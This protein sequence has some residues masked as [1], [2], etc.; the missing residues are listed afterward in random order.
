MQN[1]FYIYNIYKL[2]LQNLFWIMQITAYMFIKSKN[3][4]MKRTSLHPMHMYFYLCINEYLFNWWYFGTM[5][6]QILNNHLI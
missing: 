3:K 2:S 5:T 1:R 4:P 6:H